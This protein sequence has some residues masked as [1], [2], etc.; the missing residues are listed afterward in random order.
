VDFFDE[1][2]ISSTAELIADKNRPIKSV[3]FIGRV[4]YKNWPILSFVCRWLY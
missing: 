3:D 4:S 1:I 2:R